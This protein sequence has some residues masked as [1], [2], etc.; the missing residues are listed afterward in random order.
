MTLRRA[1]IDRWFPLGLAPLVLLVI[2][3][4]A[5]ALRFQTVGAKG[6]RERLVFW[7]FADPHLA[8]YEDLIEDFEREHGVEVE[9]RN[10]HW[11]VIGRRLRAAMWSGEGVPDLVEIPQERVGSFFSGP[12][13]QIG[14]EELTDRVNELSPAGGTIRDDVIEPRLLAYSHRG[15]IYGFPH[16]VHPTAIAYRWRDFEQAG[17]DPATLTT[18]DAFIEAGQ[19]LTRRERTPGSPTDDRRYMLSIDELTCNT[20]QTFYA[21]RG[22]NW[23]DADGAL[24]LDSDLCYETLLWYIRMAYGPDRIADGAAPFPNAAFFQAIKEGYYVC[25]ICPDWLTKN[26]EDNLP[27]FGGELRLMP[28]PAFTEGGRRTSTWGATMLSV[29]TAGD[30]EDLAWALAKHLYMNDEVSRRT[31]AEM[32][33]VSPFRSTWDQPVYA[34]PREYWSGQPIGKLFLDLAPEVPTLT[35]APFVPLAQQRA[36]SVVSEVASYYRVNGE[37]GFEAYTRERLDAAAS[38]IRKQMKRNPF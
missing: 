27:G 19:M 20:F 24:L 11:R 31:F 9:A 23:F 1:A 28:M 10:V 35:N 6:D 8:V 30:N 14:L 38:Y 33:I 17:V 2:A 25:F 5:F 37:N 13:D 26:I 18:W 34:E 29:T 32:N 22:G 16:D 3:A 7:S 15:G 21:Q 12:V 4:I 36:T